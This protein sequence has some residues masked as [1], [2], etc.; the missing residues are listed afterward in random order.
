MLSLLRKSMKGKGCDAIA[1]HD[2]VD[3]MNV[4]DV[5]TKQTVT[6]QIWSVIESSSELSASL[7]IDDKMQW[8]GQVRMI[9]EQNK[10]VN[11]VLAQIV[12]TLESAG[13]HSILLKGQG[14]AT[15][16]PKPQYRTSGDIDLLVGK[17]HFDEVRA[18][19]DKVGLI[20]E[21]HHEDVIHASMTCKGISFELHKT[22][23]ILPGKKAN[24]AFQKEILS[25]LNEHYSQCPRVNIPLTDLCT[26]SVSVAV[27]PLELNVVYVFIHMFRH[28]IGGGV[29]LR[30]VCDWQ[31]LFHASEKTIENKEK[32]GGY[33]RDFG[34]KKPWKDF[35]KMID[36]YFNGGKSDE[37]SEKIMALLLEGP[38]VENYQKK[39]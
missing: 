33:L 36:C 35:F 8:F 19:L 20:D 2:D 34:Y 22:A 31:M 12:T 6:G 13:L 7:S 37:R 4:L 29:R 10:A 17:E 30:Q 18:C 38:V 5:A 3:W 39:A 26:S 32:I 1:F 14:N 25:C 15:F 24:I 27:L 23:A 9:V 16:Y 21:W 11:K 28:F